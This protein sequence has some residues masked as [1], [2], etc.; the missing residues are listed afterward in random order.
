MKLFAVI[1]ITEFAK[2]EFPNG[3]KFHKYIK[4]SPAND[5]HLVIK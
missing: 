1:R 2:N 3:G 4:I 5:L